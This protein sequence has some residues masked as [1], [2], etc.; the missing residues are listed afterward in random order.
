MDSL[1]T[2][3]ITNGAIDAENSWATL[4]DIPFLMFNI[5]MAVTGHKNMLVIKDVTVIKIMPILTETILTE[6]INNQKVPAL[7]INNTILISLMQASYNSKPVHAVQRFLQMPNG[8][9]AV[10]SNL[11]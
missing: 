6:T 7:Q 9:L 5:I 11:I 1:T 3:H 2:N 10:V 4:K 8:A